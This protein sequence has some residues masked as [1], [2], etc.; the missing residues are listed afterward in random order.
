MVIFLIFRLALWT[1]HA[2]QDNKIDGQMPFT[3]EAFNGCFGSRT[4]QCSFCL[5]LFLS[6]FRFVLYWFPV[7]ALCGF[8]FCFRLCHWVPSAAPSES[9]A[10][11]LLASSRFGLASL[12]VVLGHLELLEDDDLGSTDDERRKDVNTKHLAVAP[13]RS[14]MAFWLVLS[15]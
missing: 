15:R 8:C 4:Q 7:F 2:Y 3:C 13:L 11:R 12:G 10:Y 5:F 6:G 14:G 1:K 9:R